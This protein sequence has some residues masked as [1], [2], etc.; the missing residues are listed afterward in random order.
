MD[1]LKLASY[2]GW[3]YVDVGGISMGGMITQWVVLVLDEFNATSKRKPI[4]VRR[5]MLGCTTPGGSGPRDGC[6]F[7]MA[8]PLP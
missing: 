7:A 8:H 5:V 6:F 2:L 1:T 4:C 3:D